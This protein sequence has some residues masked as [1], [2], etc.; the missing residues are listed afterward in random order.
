M[1]NDKIMELAKPFMSYGDSKV[2]CIRTQADIVGFAKEMMGAAV[3]SIACEKM[4]EKSL[5]W[6]WRGISIWR[7]K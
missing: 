1:T 2:P 7:T 5:I 6:R 4:E 3:K